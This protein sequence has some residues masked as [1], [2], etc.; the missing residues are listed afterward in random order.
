MTS[1]ITIIDIAHK[2]LLPYTRN[3]NTGNKY[4]IKTLLH[5]LRA[6]GLTNDMLDSMTSLIDGLKA[7]NRLHKVPEFID[8]C[9]SHTRTLPV[10]SGFILDGERIV[11]LRNTTQ[12]DGDGKT[13]D[14]IA[15]TASGEEKGISICGGKQRNDGKIAKCIINPSAKSLG[16]TPED[17]AAYDA[18]AVCA[19]TEFKADRIAKY[20]ADE[21]VWPTRKETVAAVTAASDA[22]LIAESRFTSLPSERKI[23][24]FQYLL[25]IDEVSAKP[26]DYLAIADPDMTKPNNFYKFGDPVFPRWE[27]RI[28][29]KGIYLDL[30]NCDRIVGRLQVKFNNGVYHKGKTS[31]LYSSWNFTVNLRDIFDLK[32][33]PIVVLK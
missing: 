30:Y 13:A 24:I 1:S 29:A 28:V 11:D 32:G 31:S 16:A 3:C 6:M 33:V 23:A 20:G 9:I 15:V 2:V 17:V 7:R 27:P 26:A 10:G 4:E 22:A 19:V 8:G 18:R 14:V 5:M 12:D 21:S 25:H